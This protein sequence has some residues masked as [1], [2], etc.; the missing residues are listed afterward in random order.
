MNDSLAECQG[1]KT[2]DSALRPNG[3]S[4]RCAPAVRPLPDCC[5]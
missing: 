5:A 4:I 2:F 1:N 3:L